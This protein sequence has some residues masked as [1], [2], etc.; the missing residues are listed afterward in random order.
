MSSARGQLVSTAINT[1]LTGATD[2]KPG[3]LG[4]FSAVKGVRNIQHSSPRELGRSSRTQTPS[5]GTATTC[6]PWGS[7]RGSHPQLLLETGV[8]NNKLK[9]YEMAEHPAA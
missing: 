2:G 9:V 4:D 3:E 8:R 7:D 1:M 5:H 6:S